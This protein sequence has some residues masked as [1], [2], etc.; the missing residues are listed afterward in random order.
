MPVTTQLS[1]RAQDIVGMIDQQ[2]VRE[3][4]SKLVDDCKFCTPEEARSILR[5]NSTINKAD[6][7]IDIDERVLFDVEIGVFKMANNPVRY[8]NASGV[9]VDTVMPTN[10]S[11]AM[12]T[13]PSSTMSTSTS[14]F[15]ILTLGRIAYR[16]YNHHK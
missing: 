14:G 5:H 10:S 1:S 3:L 16:L 7:S 12:C 9:L 13:N 8:Q 2:M 15:I 4:Q 11:S 6:V